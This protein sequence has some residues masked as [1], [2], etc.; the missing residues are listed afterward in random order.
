MSKQRHLPDEHHFAIANVAV[1]AAQ[2]DHVIDGLA[3]FMVRPEPVSKYLVRTIG[4]DRLLEIIRLALISELSGY[5]TQIAELFGR[6]TACRTNRNHILHWLSEGGAKDDIVRFTD[7]RR[8]RDRKPK[9]LTAKEIQMVADATFE[10]ADELLEWW[11]FYNW[12]TTLHDRPDLLARPP[13]WALPRKL[14]R[15]KASPLKPR[16]RRP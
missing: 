6:V 5:E 12:H 13:R 10:C 2:L 4:T 11:N 15:P 1:R 9:D 14:R 7:M 3:Y 8:G 16:R